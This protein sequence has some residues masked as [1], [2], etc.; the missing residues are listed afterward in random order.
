MNSE[1]RLLIADENMDVRR[2]HCEVLNSAGYKSTEEAANAGDA[3]GIA[4]TPETPADDTSAD[5]AVT[6]EDSAPAGGTSVTEQS[7][8]AQLVMVQE[9]P[10]SE[11][12][13]GQED[14]PAPLPMAQPSSEGDGEEVSVSPN[15]ADPGSAASIQGHAETVRPLGWKR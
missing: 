6:T 11:L 8:T 2:M 12:P 9:T 15:T 13:E 7:N 3:D 5:G 4:E 1:I 10:A 14:D